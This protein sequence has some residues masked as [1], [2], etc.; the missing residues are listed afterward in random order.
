MLLSDGADGFNDRQ[1]FCFPPQ[2]DVLLSDLEVPIPTDIPALH[3]VY[4]VHSVGTLYT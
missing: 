2:R 4:A 1:P 3:Q